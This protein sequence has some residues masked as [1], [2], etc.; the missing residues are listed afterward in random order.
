MRDRLLV[1]TRKGLFVFVRGDDLKWEQRSASFVG[2]P[3]TM[4]LSDPRDGTLYAALDLGHY[5]PKLRRS[6]DEGESWTEVGVPEYP[7]GSDKA[8]KM[9][10]CLESAGD[11]RPESLWAGTVPGG[12]FRSDDRGESWKLD[13][14]LWEKPE[15]EAWFGGGYD[16]PGIHSVCVDPNDSR[17]IVLGV[18][19]G[20]V[21]ISEDEGASWACSTSGMYA[22][23]MPPERRE[24]GSIQDPHRVVQCRAATE[25][26]WVQH[27]NGVFR[28][29]NKGASWE[30][31]SPSPSTCRKHTRLSG[32]STASSKLVDSS[33]Q[34]ANSC[35]SSTWRRMW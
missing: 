9:I 29:T 34:E 18:S 8:L 22:E 17:H 21:W 3:V 28:S 19:C 23:Y 6:E 13:V 24:D 16:D 12:L 7:K 35:A 20:G 26:L 25:V 31:L 27:H 5:G 1:G 10:W 11:D 14:G 30:E 2:D 32:G 33:T 4:V 15:R